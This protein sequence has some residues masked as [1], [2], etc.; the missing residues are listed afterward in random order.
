MCFTLHASGSYAFDGG[1]ISTFATTKT[2]LGVLCALARQQYDPNWRSNR[3]EGTAP[4]IFIT[5]LAPFYLA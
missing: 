2:I 3:G 4:T 5:F 1:Y